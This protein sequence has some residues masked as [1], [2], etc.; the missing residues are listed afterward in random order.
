MS[1]NKIINKEDI[2]LYSQMVMILTVFVLVKMYSIYGDLEIALITVPIIG[3]A[4]IED[5]AKYRI[6]TITLLLLVIVTPMSL[7]TY[8][9]LDTIMNLSVLL[10]LVTMTRK[11]KLLSKADVLVLILVATV[12]RVNMFSFVII[13]M[14]AT[15]LYIQKRYKVSKISLIP[16][17]YV[18]FCITIQFYTQL[19]TLLR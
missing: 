7:L 5:M 15:I 18:A 16:S 12:C 2:T 4:A 10:I 9:S 6:S 8:F 11:N 14:S 13:M 3:I 19:N 1:E 17:I